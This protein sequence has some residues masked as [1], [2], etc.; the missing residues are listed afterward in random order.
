MVKDERFKEFERS[1]RNTALLNSRFTG[2]AA[3][4]LDKTGRTV[5]CRDQD[6]RD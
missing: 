5:T 1:G 2:S 3:L 4:V 6:V